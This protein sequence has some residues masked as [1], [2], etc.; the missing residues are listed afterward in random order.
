[1]LHGI[2]LVLEPGE[3]VALTGPSGSG[4]TILCLVLAGAMP[5]SRGAVRLEG[6][7]ATEIGLPPVPTLAGTG[8]YA[9][10]DAAGLVLQTHG[11][12]QGLTAT[13]NVA[14]PLQARQVPRA[15]AARRTAQA[16]SDVGLEKHAARAV[17]GLSGGERQRVGI[18]RALALDPAVLVADEPT[19]ELDPSNRERVLRLL[20]LHADKGG[21][22]VI[23]SDDPEIVNS[24]GRTVV[25]EHG[26]LAYPWVAAPTAG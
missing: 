8:G 4:K 3:P 22:V 26:T 7:P 15:E 9:G 25:L 20:K 23:A 18:A 16:L 14:L 11:L 5:A 21:I 1:V 12:V 2:D 17:D 6:G 10:S 13:E 19:A 24:C